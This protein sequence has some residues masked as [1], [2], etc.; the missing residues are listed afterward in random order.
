MRFMVIVVRVMMVVLSI[1][2]IVILVRFVV[3]LVLDWNA[4]G[5]VGAIKRYS[6]I[7]RFV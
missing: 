1:V 7:K 2:M 5:S 4:N 3:V 6:D